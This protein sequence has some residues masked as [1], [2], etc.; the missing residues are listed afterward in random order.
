MAMPPACML[1][2]RSPLGAL[3]DVTPV[4]P[5]CVCTSTEILSL[6]SFCAAVAEAAVLAEAASVDSLV[7]PA[8][9]PANM[10]PAEA[11]RVLHIQRRRVKAWPQHCRACSMTSPL[12]SVEVAKGEAGAGP[13]ERHEGAAHR[14]RGVGG[15]EIAA[16]EADIGH[17][18]VGEHELVDPTPVGPDIAHRT[19]NEG[20]RADVPLPVDGERIE[21]LVAAEPDHDPTLLATIRSVGRLDLARP[22][23]LESPAA[24]GGRLHDVQGLL[25]R[26]EPDAVA[27]LQGKDRLADHRPV[28]LRV[29]HNAAVRVTLP[30]LPQVRE[31]EAAGAVEDEIVRPAEALAFTAVVECLELA[32][33]GIHDLNA[34][35]DVVVGLEH[36]EELAR[37]LYALE[38]T[39]VGH[40]DL[41]ARAHGR[42]VRAAT[43]GGDHVDLPVGGDA[44]QGPALDLDEDDRA[45]RHGH[46]PFGKTQAGGDL[47]DGGGVGGHHDLPVAFC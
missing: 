29:V 9:Q 41:A 15:A 42:A 44:R 23:E 30:R 10:A 11:I 25:V 26:R 6:R 19:G 47:L 43:Q 16:A 12:L 32:C 5:A 13:L 36:G 3:C 8:A 33:F 7:R 27:P 40:E 4:T 20:G 28:G 34:A 14:Q 46:R 18:H 2:A 35:A 37:P 31:P 45:V 24:G 38:A 17:H 1:R 21:H 22:R 39:I